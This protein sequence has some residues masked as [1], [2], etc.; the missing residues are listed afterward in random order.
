MENIQVLGMATTFIGNYSGLC[1]N[2]TFFAKSKKMVE[3]STL[4]CSV[5]RTEATF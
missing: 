3:L 5:R 1:G 4:F 2:W